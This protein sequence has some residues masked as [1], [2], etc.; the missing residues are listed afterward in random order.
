MR[1]QRGARQRWR[2][3]RPGQSGSFARSLV[4]AKRRREDLVFAFPDS[5][6]KAHEGL[7]LG[8]G[9]QLDAVPRSYQISEVVQVLGL[10]AP[11]RKTQLAAKSFAQVFGRRKS[12]GRLEAATECADR[13]LKSAASAGAPSIV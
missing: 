9:G 7:T 4:I 3:A 6:A 12:G 5:P 10:A 2:P 1:R 8:L 11:F 13:L